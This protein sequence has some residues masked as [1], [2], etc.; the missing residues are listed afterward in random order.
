MKAD[1]GTE[2]T[3][4]KRII[5]TDAE[6][7]DRPLE[8]REWLSLGTLALLA[9]LA[10]ALSVG[11]DF[12]YD[13]V[14]IIRDNERL[15]SLANWRLILTSPWWED[16]L[17]RPLTMLTF[18]L[19]W[20]LAKGDPGWF[21][22]VNV[23]LHGAV[24][25]LV[26]VL[27]RGM[28][29][30][31]GAWSA[32]ALFAV[33]PV[34]VEAVANVVGRA[35]VLAGLFL[36]ASVILYRRDGLLADKGVEGARRALT[37]FGTL[38][39]ML[40]AAASKEVGF[41][42]PGLLLLADWHHAWTSRSTLRAAMGRHRVLWIA[43]V[44]LTA[45]WLWIWTSVLGGIRG[46]A[47][48][49]GLVGAGIGRRAIVMSPV[50][51]EYL[52]LL[53]FPVRLS[54][55]Y[56]PN[57]LPVADHL[58]LKGVVGLGLLVAAV[59]GAAASRRV[60][61]AVTFGAAW[62]A[63]TLFIV[64]NILWPTEVLLAERTLYVPSIGAMIALGALV[65]IAYYRWPRSVPALVGLLV[66]LGLGRSVARVPVWRDNETFFPQ[67]V[68]DAPGSFRSLW[69]EG[70]L[71]YQAGDS[72]RG[73]RL[74]KQAI[75]VYPLHPSVWSDLAKQMET[76]GRW[77]EAAAYY[78]TAFRLDSTRIESAA[79]ALANYLRAGL[80]D[81]AASVAARA[82]DVAPRHPVVMVARSDLAM[83]EGKPL[84]A[85]TLRRQVALRFPG[86][87]QNWYVTAKA[88]IAARYCPEIR[89]SLGRLQKLRPDHEELADLERQA[90]A[91]GCTLH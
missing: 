19:D 63:G 37:S 8:R 54:A 33:H 91:A 79:F 10:Y 39:T 90:E 43:S 24:T 27:A 34:H 80:V 18:A 14:L 56:S 4:A 41:V 85:M 30:P 6:Q 1:L 58:T 76:Q 60:A 22:A 44:V 84:E 68:R 52:R 2:R 71:S 16:A 35:D 15:H 49:P 23:I 38:G 61:P 51:V 40:A 78:H 29:T 48:A 75:E 74:V 62:V 72:A 17:Y 55:D 36:A 65:A 12:T 81:S 42:G 53:L 59:A 32:A 7:R 77:R 89:R 69:V 50:I 87:W 86:A 47:E 25:A 67:L 70:A 66:V 73:E 31:P 13:D 5:V 83:A 88:A 11:H 9:L 21:H 3:R 26:F 46:G 57:F 64:A 20:S 45:Q 82:E 28:L